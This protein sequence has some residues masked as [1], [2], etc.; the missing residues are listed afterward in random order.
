M[1]VLWITYDVFDYLKSSIKGKPSIGRPWVQPLFENLIKSEGITLATLTP[2][3]DG[4]YQ[5]IILNSSTHFIIPKDNNYL[6]ISSEM[7]KGFLSVINYFKPDIIHIHGTEINYGLLRKYVDLSI[8]IICSIQGIIPPCSFFLKQ[9]VSNINYKRYRS[10]KNILGKGGIDGA[11]RYWK[12]YTPIEKE[13][14]QKNQYFIGR[15]VWDKAYLNA[16]NPNATYYHGEELLRP[17]FYS[18]KW[19]INTCERHR[20]F[21]S[22]SA[23]SLK[24]FHVLLKAAGILKMKYPNLKI[25]SPLSSLKQDRSKLI[26]LLISEDY[27]NYLKQEIKKQGLENNLEL[28][29]NLS[30]V[31]MAQE[32]KRAHIFVM[33]SFLENSPNSLGEAMLVGTPSVVT[34]VGGILSIIQSEVSSIVFPA[35]DHIVMAYQIDRLFSDDDLA[36]GISINAKIVASKRH[37][38]TN[39]VSQY[40]DIYESVI[41]SHI[42][43]NKQQ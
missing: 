25:V 22:S 14:F 38:I 19:D 35:D 18:T 34:P 42:R 6:K 2:V 23:Y 3:L 8:P 20:I 12:K 11:I 30:E 7:V 32:Y 27:S 31:D 41:E 29:H 26:D 40:K 13:I 4:Y 43:N 5:K 39:T 37:N 33:P 17:S 1:K 10:I 16:Y 9:S 15:T 28:K 36:I 21:I 24:G